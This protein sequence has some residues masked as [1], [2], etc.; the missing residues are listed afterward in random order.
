M[1]SKKGKGIFKSLPS[2]PGHNIPVLN[3]WKDAEDVRKALEPFFKT[4][5]GK[6]FQKIFGGTLYDAIT[7][8]IQT[9]TETLA[10]VPTRLNNIT[11]KTLQQ[12]G[13]IP[14]SSP[15]VII[16]TPL[17]KY[18][19][20]A[21]NFISLGKVKELQKK[22]NYDKL[23]HLS[24]IVVVGGHKIIVEKNEV[25]H[26][27]PLQDKD[28][29][30]ETEFF[31]I[32][33]K[34]NVDL[35]LNNML[36]RT[37]EI[38]GHHLF[39]SYSALGNNNCQDFIRNFLNSSDLLTPQASNFIFQNMTSLVNDLKKSGYGY[40]PKVV[41]AITDTASKVSRFIG[42]GKDNTE[43][44]KIFAEFVNNQGFKFL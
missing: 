29:N 40:V 1:P 13:D 41:D 36:S 31:H 17:N 15:L 25:V 32:N 12:V 30:N 28:I 7:T 4:D 16:R 18:L 37:K 35:T 39:Y 38:M 22:Y 27:G 21:L 9:I 8:P 20:H 10:P 34:P 42:K 33:F 24:V 14:I 26:V 43:N 19:T 5:K 6:E 3:P 23:F 11:T 2:F 44:G